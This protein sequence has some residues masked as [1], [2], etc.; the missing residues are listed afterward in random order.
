MRPEIRINEIFSEEHNEKL[1]FVMQ[2]QIVTGSIKI[3]S[4]INLPFSSGLD[5]TIPVDA[6]E[7]S[8]DQIIRIKVRCE[9]AEEIEFLRGLNLVGETLIVE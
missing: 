6:I 3:G 2:C 8:N 7:S 4:N 9:D 5:M 1:F